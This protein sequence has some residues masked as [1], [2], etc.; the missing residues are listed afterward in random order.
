MAGNAPLTVTAGQAA[1][2]GSQVPAGASVDRCADQITFASKSVSFVVEASPPDGPDMTFRVAGLVDPTIVVPSG[3]QVDVEFINADSDEAHGWII[4]TAD[5][6][7][8]FGQTSTPA[9]PGAYAGVIGNP[10]SAGQGARTIS[11]T[12][13]T[14]GTYHYVCPMPGHAQMGMNG[15]FIVRP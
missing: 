12:V 6:P 15:T 14:A 5:P 3:A 10:T 2:L 13:A 4:T 7:F 1:T 11:F 9:I 8:A